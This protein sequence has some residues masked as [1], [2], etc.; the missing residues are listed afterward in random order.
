MPERLWKFKASDTFRDLYHTKTDELRKRTK[1]L[2]NLIAITKNP[3]TLGSKKK[4]LDFWAADIAPDVRLAYNVDFQD[5]MVLLVKV[6][7][8]KELYGSGN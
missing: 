5:R 2:I 7:S 4:N 3:L 1:D 8:H 6:C